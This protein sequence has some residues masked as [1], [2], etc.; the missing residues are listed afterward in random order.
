MKKMKYSATAI[1]IIIIIFFS[2]SCKSNINSIKTN[3]LQDLSI[4]GNVRTIISTIYGSRAEN[5][6]IVGGGLTDY[7]IVVDEYDEYGMSTNQV[8]N[9]ANEHMIDETCWIYNEDNLLLRVEFSN[10]DIHGCTKME[11]KYNEYDEL[12][13]MD[14]FDTESKIF[15]S[16]IITYHSSGY[17]HMERFLDENGE[18]ISA[19][20]FMYNNN[21]VLVERLGHDVINNH[22]SETVYEYDSN[23]NVTLEKTID[24]NGNV[25]FLY[26]RKYDENNNLLKYTWSHGKHVLTS[27]KY[28]Y[29]YDKLNNWVEKSVFNEK[30][31][32]QY[33]KRAIEYY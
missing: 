8:I 23:G 6:T 5:G 11:Y 25:I 19:S 30:E 27:E 12:I 3:S 18:D 7:I 13:R 2:F 4:N 20:E 22:K 26:E 28:E 14:F 9:D 31:K 33:I 17:K 16:V 21:N 15:Q 10:Y 32:V 24:E 1:G 29:I